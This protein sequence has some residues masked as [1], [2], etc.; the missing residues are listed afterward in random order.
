MKSGDIIFVRGHSPIS[1]AIKYFDRGEFSH[2]CMAV[3]STHIIEAE[4][5]MKSSIVPYHY[6]DVKIISLQLDSDKIEQL[7]KAAIELTGKRYDYIQIL[8]YVFSEK[9]GSPNKL[10]C[11]ELVYELLKVIG[12]DAGSR[13]IEPNELYTLLCKYIEKGNI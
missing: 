9:W 8:G 5:G 6:K 2:V 3:S 13:F 1:S 10:I 12:I 7:V 4:Y 11:S